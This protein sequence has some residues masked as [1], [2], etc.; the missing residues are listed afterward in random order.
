MEVNESSQG[1]GPEHKRFACHAE[2]LGFYL[3]GS[4]N[5]YILSGGLET[6]SEKDH[7]NCR[8]KESLK[9]MEIEKD[10]KKYIEIFG[11]VK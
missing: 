11:G 3:K 8:I 1:H 10:R 5:H 6:P 7:F 4:N 9:S 2:E